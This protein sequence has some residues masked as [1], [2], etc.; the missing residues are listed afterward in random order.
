MGYRGKLTSAQVLRT[1]GWTTVQRP[2]EVDA[3]VAAGRPM[4]RAWMAMASPPCLRPRCGIFLRSGK[5]SASR[6]RPASRSPPIP[7][8]PRDWGSRMN[9]IE[10]RGLAKR[11]ARL[12]VA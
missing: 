3:A 2:L 10:C 6:H 12:G 1:G 7:S 9:V 11:Y 5:E 8:R 4:M